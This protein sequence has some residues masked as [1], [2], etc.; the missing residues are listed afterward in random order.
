MKRRKFILSVVAMLT[1]MLFSAVNSSVYAK[2]SKMN[3]PKL[4]IP[5]YA[6]I[7]CTG[8]LVQIPDC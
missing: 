8:S 6:V 2:K 4:L 7:V 3:L 5:A 1:A